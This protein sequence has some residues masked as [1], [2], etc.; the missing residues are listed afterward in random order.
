MIQILNILIE[1]SSVLQNRHNPVNM[2]KNSIKPKT[3]FNKK[4]KPIK[5]Q[6][7]VIHT[8]INKRKNKS[9]KKST[10]NKQKSIFKNNKLTEDLQDPLFYKMNSTVHQFNETKRNRRY[11]NSD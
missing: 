11:S 9:N 1:T 8:K 5:F 6:S 4:L 3:S 10:L 7:S 2:N